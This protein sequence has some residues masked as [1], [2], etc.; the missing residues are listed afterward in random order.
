MGI[1]ELK[2]AVEAIN[3]IAILLCERF[4]DGLGV[5]DAV[6]IYDKIK[7]DADFK[8]K[9]IAAYDNYKLIPE[10]IKDIDISEGLEVA[11][12]QIGYVSKIIEALKK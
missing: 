12:I 8:A 1:K 2:E 11:V 4:K 9:M 5:D 10:E 3:E 7:E 6:A